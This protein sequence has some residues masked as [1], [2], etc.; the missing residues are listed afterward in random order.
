V[1]RGLGFGMNIAGSSSVAGNQALEVVAVR[2]VGAESS[3]IKQAFDAAAQA[4]LIGVIL[5]AHR[6]THIAV[7]AT[8]EQHHSGCPQPRDHHAQGPQPTRILF[9]FI[10]HNHQVLPK[11]KD[12]LNP[13]TA[14]WAW[15]CM[16]GNGFRV[17]KKAQAAAAY[18]RAPGILRLR[19]NRCNVR[20]MLWPKASGRR[21]LTCGAN[22]SNELKAGEVKND[23]SPVRLTFSK[24]RFPGIS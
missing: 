4:N 2:P 9:L 5:R 14:Q 13:M 10:C 18:L 11:L 1:F 7:P 3:L 20:V 24:P 12:M 16:N 22:R 23:L 8:A 15:K 21:G 17:W 19:R 6:P